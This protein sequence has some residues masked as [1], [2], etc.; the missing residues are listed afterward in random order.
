M[1][2]DSQDLRERVLRACERGRLTERDRAALRGKPGAPVYQVWQLSSL[3]RKPGSG[4]A[5]GSAGIG[6]HGLPTTIIIGAPGLRKSR[7]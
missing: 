2:A 7:I 5:C 4:A 3:K 1:A 6:G